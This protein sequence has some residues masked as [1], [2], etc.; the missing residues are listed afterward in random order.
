MT[1]VLL[2]GAVVGLG[3][4]L[5][6]LQLDE[7]R[8]SGAAQLA[9][10]D[11]ARAR[12]RRTSGLTGGQAGV[13]EE[14]LR[15]RRSGARLRAAMESRG[16]DL[17]P[18]MQADLA[19]IGRT[20]EGH[21]ANSVLTAVAGAFAPLFALLPLIATGTVTV[22]VPAWLSLLGVVIA[23][24]LPTLQLRSK[25]AERR[26]D[27]RHAVSA[28]LDLVSMNLAGGRGVPEA[29]SSASGISH[30]WAMVR[31]RDT[32]QTARLQGIT[33]W[34]ALGQLGE[35]VAVEELRDLA[36][37]LALV[38]EDGAKVRESLAARASSMRQRE[39]ADAESRAA[40]RSQSM[41]VAQLLLCVGFLLFLTYPGVARILSF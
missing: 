38:A 32:L 25:A 18:S 21:L 20:V 4:L 8:G 15:M 2:A 34:A 28:F 30:G 27:F 9:A 10:L 3:V 17:P 12:A 37:T 35:E 29:L 39:L 11:S 40:Q 36:A 22:S 33:P 5:L 14:S 31:I 16:W 1:A 19:V 7:S 23:G 13:R 41:L 26:R 24:A 6:A